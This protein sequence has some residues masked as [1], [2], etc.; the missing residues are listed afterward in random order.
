MPVENGGMPPPYRLPGAYGRI[1]LGRGDAAINLYGNA[2]LST[3]LRCGLGVSEGPSLITHCEA[4]GPLLMGGDPWF[5]AT[6]APVV[7]VDIVD[8]GVGRT[9]HA[10]TLGLEHTIVLNSHVVPVPIMPRVA[11]GVSI[12]NGSAVPFVSAG[13]EVALAADRNGALTLGAAYRYDERT[14]HGG[15]LSLGFRFGEFHGRGLSGSLF[16]RG[17]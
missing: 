5:A 9:T 13:V 3:S 11:Y 6:V 2:F 15:E 1:P 17:E 12:A 14:G 4:S 8:H 16:T 10:L 7:G